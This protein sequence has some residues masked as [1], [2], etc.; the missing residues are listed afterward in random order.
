M[1]IIPFINT[2]H[3]TSHSICETLTAYENIVKPIFFFEFLNII[4]ASFSKK[5]L[6]KKEKNPQK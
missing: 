3:A 4:R 2:C 1:Q 6:H 5:Y